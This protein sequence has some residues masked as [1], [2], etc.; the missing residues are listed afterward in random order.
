MVDFLTYLHKPITN[1][2]FSHICNLLYNGMID[3]IP[4]PSF[5]YHAPM[6]IRSRPNF[7]NKMFG[8]E[9]EI[10]YNSR[11]LDLIKP[12][13]FNMPNQGMFYGCG[14]GQETSKED[15]EVTSC[16]ESY[17]DVLSP[18]NKERFQ[19]FTTGVWEVHTPL[20]L[21]NLGHNENLMLANPML[22]TGIDFFMR[23]L[24]NIFPASSYEFIIEF[25]NFFCDLAARKNEIG[26]EHFLS[27]AFSTATFA[28]YKVVYPKEI[29]GILY[30]SPITNN[31]GINIVLNPEAVDAHMKLKSVFMLKW[32]RDKDNPKHYTIERCSDEVPVIDGK[33]RLKKPF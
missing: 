32:I 28:Y 10:S 1:E 4:I 6:M 22:K 2:N 26:A 8:E 33:F 11:R 20:K 18:I 30:A 7:D 29:N 14:P 12:G 9:W 27:T 31:F 21:I 15:F 23:E 16:L 13:R 5:D 3:K 24:R 17:K 19:Y 25:W